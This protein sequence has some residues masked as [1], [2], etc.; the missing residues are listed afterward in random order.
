MGLAMQQTMSDFIAC[1]LILVYRPFNVGDYVDLGKG[2]QGTV[3]AINFH[4]Y[5]NLIDAPWLVNGGHGA[6]L[7]S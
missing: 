2:L 4:H 7:K 5:C 3:V 6:S 1:T